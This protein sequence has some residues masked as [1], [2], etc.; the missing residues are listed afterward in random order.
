MN[1]RLAVA[2]LRMR[3]GSSPTLRSLTVP[4]QSTLPVASGGAAVENC[5]EGGR[6]EQGVDVAR[7]HLPVTDTVRQ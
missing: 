2:K 7:W 3:D 6:D 5:R 4:R 1:M